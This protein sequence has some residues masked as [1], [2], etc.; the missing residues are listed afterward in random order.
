MMNQNKRNLLRGITLTK[1]ADESGTSLPYLSKVVS[2][3]LKAS[4][5]KALNLSR[6]ANKLSPY[7]IFDPNDF[8][9][10]LSLAL[11]NVCDDVMF[12]VHCV[13][14]K[15]TVYQSAKELQETCND[16][17][18]LLVCLNN[19]VSGE[20]SQTWGSLLIE[21]KPDDEPGW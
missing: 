13:V 4:K 10:T 15:K 21:L 1:L 6:C 9:D 17:L 16:D 3:K 12:R 14:T 8:N 18:D 19:L 11:K 5:D 7:K 20:H 2:G